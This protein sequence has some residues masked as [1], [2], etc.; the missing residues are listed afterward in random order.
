MVYPAVKRS[1]GGG[2]GAAPDRR[3]ESLVADS[4]NHAM[5]TASRTALTIVMH[6]VMNIVMK[7][8]SKPHGAGGGE[9][10]SRDSVNRA[11]KARRQRRA[12]RETETILQLLESRIFHRARSRNPIARASPRDC[13]ER[14]RARPPLCAPPP[15]THLHLRALVRPPP[16]TRLHLRAL[17]RP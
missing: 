2:E 6:I 4:M 8:D 3:H 13:A 10:P 15:H 12:G 17:I 14:P 16:H 11:P 5:E 1:G 7:I 9:G